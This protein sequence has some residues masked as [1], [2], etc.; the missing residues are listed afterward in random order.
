MAA[1]WWSVLSGKETT[2]NPQVRSISEKTTP[3]TGSAPRARAK[4][5]VVD[6]HALVR[7]GLSTLI[8]SEPDLEVCGEAA[9]PAEAL[10]RLGTQKPDLVIVDLSLQDGHGLDLIRQLRAH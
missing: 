4:I 10:A 2:M 5:M 6:D 1:R 3:E 9:G 8:G 7:R